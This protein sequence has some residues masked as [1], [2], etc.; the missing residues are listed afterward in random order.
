MFKALILVAQTSIQ[1]GSR[2]RRKF[3]RGLF[4]ACMA[5]AVTLALLCLW[6]ATAVLMTRLLPPHETQELWDGMHV[7][8]NSTVSLDSSSV[9]LRS[10][11]ITFM[12]EDCNKTSSTLSDANTK[13]IFVP[14]VECADLP[15]TNLTI[16]TKDAE[17]DL[18]YALPGSQVV[19]NVFENASEPNIWLTNYDLFKD[20]KFHH[21]Y[22]NCSDFSDICKTGERGSTVTFNITKADFYMHTYMYNET[23]EEP[24]PVPKNSLEWHYDFLVYDLHNIKENQ[25]LSLYDTKS[26]LV[27]VAPTFRF[28]RKSCTLIKLLETYETGTRFSCLRITAEWRWEVTFLGSLVCLVC[29]LLC[30]TSIIL[31][32]KC[33]QKH[34]DAHT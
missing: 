29:V 4:F 6:V 18:F 5:A 27:K 34:C 20:W 26:V 23:Q 21:G 2:Q 24:F 19:I 12:N 15:T 7:R 33:K 25:D 1:H 9:W 32:A 10:F 22:K 11:N 8:G 16:N 13:V 31:V 3:S 14:D 30:L 28:R 17:P